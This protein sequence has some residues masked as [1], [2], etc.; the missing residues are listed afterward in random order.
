MVGSCG[1]IVTRLRR[2]VRPIFDISVRASQNI[3]IDVSGELT[4]TIYHDPPCSSFHE[5]KEAQRKGRLAAT[6]RANYTNLL[7]GC[8]IKRNTM[9]DVWQFRLAYET[10]SVLLLIRETRTV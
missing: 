8:H 6:R 3:S 10:W 5:T 1:M 7:A 9:E 2:S 4:E